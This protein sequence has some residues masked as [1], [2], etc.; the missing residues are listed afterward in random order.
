VKSNITQLVDRLETEGLV[1][2]VGDS[3]DRRCVR[4]AITATGRERFEQGARVVAEIERE[5]FGQLGEDD[6]ER[7][8]RLFAS[9]GSPCE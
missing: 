3:A 7:L 5:L 9:F 1:E 8:V 4:A 2:R 6:R